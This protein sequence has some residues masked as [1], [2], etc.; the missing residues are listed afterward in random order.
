MFE[1]TD[2]RE[3]F[4]TLLNNLQP[5][6]SN[7][8]NDMCPICHDDFDGDDFCCEGPPVRMPCCRKTLG[9]T[10]VLRCLTELCPWC[11]ATIYGDRPHID[12]IDCLRQI[13]ESTTQLPEVNDELEENLRENRRLFQQ[14]IDRIDRLRQ[15]IAGM[16]QR[17]REN[18]EYKNYLDEDPLL[19]L[20]YR[21]RYRAHEEREP[22]QEADTNDDGE[23]RTIPGGNE[24][25]D[26][27]DDELIEF[28]RDDIAG[29]SRPEGH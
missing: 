4:I 24:V 25:V 29:L 21:A 11:R 16:T 27:T 13:I 5:V 12:H 22:S 15:T 19:E 7:E 28:Y 23:A 17:L 10:C 2:S 9:R 20:Y 6:P 8:I 3:S 26:F 14:D 18:D 1:P